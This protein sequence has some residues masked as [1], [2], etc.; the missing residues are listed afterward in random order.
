M[1]VVFLNMAEEYGVNRREI[2]ES[3][4]AGQVTLAYSNLEQRFFDHDGLLDRLSE[5]QETIQREL[6]KGRTDWSAALLEERI[7]LGYLRLR[8]STTDLSVQQMSSNPE[9]GKLVY[10]Y[11]RGQGRV[12][13]VRKYPNGQVLHTG[14]L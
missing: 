3:E 8:K 14:P 5:I 7:V 9:Y 6:D 4:L 13:V 1:K 11:D 12:T 2:E 10:T